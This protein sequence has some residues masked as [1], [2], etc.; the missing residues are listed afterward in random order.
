LIY[1]ILLFVFTFFFAPSVDNMRVTI[2]LFRLIKIYSLYSVTSIS[3]LFSC[4]SSPQ[5]FLPCIAE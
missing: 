1:L 2:W 5:K 3:S 4:L